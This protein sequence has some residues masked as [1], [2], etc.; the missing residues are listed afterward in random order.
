MGDLIDLGAARARRSE[1]WVSKR[2][3]ADHLGVHPKTVERYMRE[4]GLPFEK[5]YPTSWPRFKRSDVD[6]W[7]RRRAS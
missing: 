2:E 1:P 6:A 3:I 5:R 4:D 7:L